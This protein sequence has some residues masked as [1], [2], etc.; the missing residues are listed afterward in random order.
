[1]PPDGQALHAADSK[2]CREGRGN[3]FLTGYILPARSGRQNKPERQRKY[4]MTR[5]HYCWPVITTNNG[6]FDL[7]HHAARNAQHG[8]IKTDVN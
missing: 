3:L 6:I 7:T 1:M 5:Q 8:K 2:M 4:L